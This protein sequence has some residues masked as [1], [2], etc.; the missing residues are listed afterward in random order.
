[1]SR[2]VLFIVTM[3]AV[4]LSF[5]AT[6]AQDKPKR[7]F[8]KAEFVNVDG[9]NLN[10]KIER[11]FRQYKSS[12]PGDLGDTVWIAFHFPA[13]EGSYIGPFSGTVYYD[14]GI[15]LERKD[16]VSQAAVF[17][18]VDAS[19]SSP[20]IKRVKTISLKEDFVFEDRMVYWLGNADA[21]QS[22]NY[23]TSL[24]R[25]SN[26]DDKEGKELA[27]GAM[28]AIGSHDNTRAVSL[29]K[30]FV[31]QESNVEL[32]RS[33]VSNL[34]RFRT[35]EGTDALISL[36]DSAKDDAVKDEIISGLSRSKERRAADKL[37]NIAQNDPNPKMRR[38]AVRRISTANSSSGVW[39]H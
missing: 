15:R 22:L 4:L 12:K 9:G 7:T 23:L 18:L 39:I 31:V 14:D 10:D 30:E 26:K 33:A 29:L 19:G 24:V 5:A 11:A 16:D 6:Y 32:Q 27:R 37:L 8:T 36:Y 20:N 3:L 38:S 28:R 35:P 2:K 17:L 25:Q 34:A 21:N 1:M 13:R